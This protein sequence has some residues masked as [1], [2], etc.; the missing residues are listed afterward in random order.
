MVNYNQWP[1]PDLLRS[2]SHQFFHGAFG[3]QQ[4]VGRSRTHCYNDLR[5]KVSYFAD[6]EAH[7]HFHL[8]VFRPAVS[9]GPT[10]DDVGDP[11]LFRFYPGLTKKRSESLAG[12][13]NKRSPLKIFVSARGLPDDH[14]PVGTVALAFYSLR[15]LPQETPRTL[16]VG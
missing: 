2:G 14:D 3:M 13:A 8:F 5:R 12:G 1:A 9:W 6:Q 10:F 11:A 16:V 4:R 7:A 15:T